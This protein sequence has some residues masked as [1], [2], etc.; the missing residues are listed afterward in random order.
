MSRSI[1][2]VLRTWY[3]GYHASHRKPSPFN[4]KHR[5]FRHCAEKRWGWRSLEDPQISGKC[6]W[7]RRDFEF[8]ETRA[9]T[10]VSV[11]TEEELHMRFIL[12]ISARP[13]HLLIDFSFDIFITW[14]ACTL[15]EL[16]ACCSLGIMR[17]HSVSNPASGPC[18][19][20]VV[21]GRFRRFRGPH[22]RIPG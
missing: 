21:P 10:M 17:P 7:Q 13:F 3:S 16:G 5:N 18:A 6:Y 20:T 9:L 12:Y 8:L 4:S 22:V 14:E 11:L 1:S 15:D 2:I 19:I